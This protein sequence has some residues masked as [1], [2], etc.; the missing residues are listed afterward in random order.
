MVTKS[1]CSKGRKTKLLLLVVALA[2]TGCGVGPGWPGEAGAAQQ[3]L[4]Y[5]G[6]DYLFIR[7]LKTWAQAKASCESLGYGLVTINDAAEEAWLRGLE[8]SS[9]WWIGYNDI[10]V[11]GSWR[12]S[13]GSSSYTNWAPGQPDNNLGQQDCAIDNWNGGQWDDGPCTSAAYYICESLL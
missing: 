10:Q 3:A 5:S 8:G 11:E 13:S 7:S 6:H 1:S 2:A 9:Y 12:W 4:M